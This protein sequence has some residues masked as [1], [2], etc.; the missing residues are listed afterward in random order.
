[1][2]MLLRLAIACAVIVA[3]M[4]L[5][6]PK[7]PAAPAT[8]ELEAPPQV[9]QI[10][11]RSCYSCHSNERRLSWF[12]QIEPGYWLV[13]KDILTARGHLNF[14][15][16]GSEAAA[17][18]KAALYEA[19]NMIQLGAMPLPRFLALHSGARV[20]P[21]ELA[22]VEEYLAP[23]GPLPSIAENAE[24]TAAPV[25]LAGVTTEPDGFPFDSTFEGW[26]PLSF[27]DRGDN[28]TFRFVLGNEI[29]IEAAR[30]GNISPW[31][32]GAR[33][34]KIAWSQQAGS[35]SLVYPGSF[36]QVELMAKDAARYKN[37]DGWGW[38]R[39]R[40]L[41][42]KP[43]GKDARF[44]EEC[45]TCHMPVR[46]NDAVYTLPITSARVR[47]EEVVNNAAAALPASL[48]YQPLAWTQLRCTW[49]V[50]PAPFPRSMEMRRRWRR[51]MHAAQIRMRLAALRMLSV[52]CWRWL[53]G[54]NGMIRTGSGRAFPTRHARWSLCR[55]RVKRVTTIINAMQEQN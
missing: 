31:P 38:G 40:G 12:D 5:V 45:T 46:G 6:R 19:V 23:W 33:F 34:A 25:S 21:E 55:L 44:V 13:R 47:G 43:Y 41:E 35:D 30:S 1:M 20:A 53:P 39:W 18:Q 4:Q 2:K 8:A 26:K 36:V 29:A 9:R 17:A 27:T 32:D 10:L 22:T 24:S 11:D 15:T 42:L 54:D 48:P 28:N 37:T 52:R 14:S 50:T 7:I 49:I 51:Y 3:L 16:I